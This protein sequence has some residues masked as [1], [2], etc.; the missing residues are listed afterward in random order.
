MRRIRNCSGW[1][2]HAGFGWRRTWGRTGPGAARTYLTS[3]SGA[4]W[5][6]REPL[7]RVS[8]TGPLLRPLC[9]RFGGEE[10]HSP[11]VQ[12][13]PPLP[14]GTVLLDLAE[15]SLAGVANQLLDRFIYEDQIR[16]QDRDELLR[17]LLLKHR[18]PCL[19]G[20]RLHS[21]MAHLPSPPAPSSPWKS[22]WPFPHHP[23]AHFSSRMALAS[24]TSG[25]VLR[26]GG[27][28]SPGGQIIKALPS[29]YS[30][31]STYTFWTEATSL[32]PQHPSEEADSPF[33][34]GSL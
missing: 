34:P 14:A 19:P 21:Q 16:P 4:S 7:P 13:T 27:H 24:D 18:C 5:S 30:S 29:I 11:A 26:F 8:P 17:V 12:L 23:G 32:H 2:Q 6:C 20:P 22:T 9:V 3:P 10:G 33:S 28:W 31:G 1:K 15:T 25:G